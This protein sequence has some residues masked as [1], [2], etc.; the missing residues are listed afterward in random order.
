MSL[1]QLLDTNHSLFCHILK[2]QDLYHVHLNQSG[3][4]L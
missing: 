2:V 3:Q 4:N 1:N